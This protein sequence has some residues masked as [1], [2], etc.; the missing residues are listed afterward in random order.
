MSKRKVN[1]QS[2]T[3]EAARRELMKPVPSWERVF[4][5]ADGANFKVPKWVKTDKQQHF[6][7][8]EDG[9]ID[10]PLAPIVDEVMDVDEENE[11][12]DVN[13]VVPNTEQGTPSTSEKPTTTVEAT[14]IP[15]D[16]PPESVL[17]EVPPETTLALTQAQLEDETTVPDVLDPAL[18]IPSLDDGDVVALGNVDMD[19]SALGTD[20]LVSDVLSAGDPLGADALGV[21]GLASDA[22]TMLPPDGTAFEA[23]QDLSQVEPDDSI[24]GGKAMDQSGDPF[25]GIPS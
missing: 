24:L 15:P 11:G 10:Q 20:V 23:A 7:D 2:A 4:V 14:P 1:F 13:E 8:D 21:D 9:A 19:L 16:V 12:E 5:T 3:S 25:G 22:L 18:A 17:E 6:S